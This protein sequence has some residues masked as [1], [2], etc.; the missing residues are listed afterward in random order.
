MSEPN[1]ENPLASSSA[2]APLRLRHRLPK[3]LPNIANLNAASRVQHRTEP[4][5]PVAEKAAPP[6]S[7]A[8]ATAPAATAENV[9]TQETVQKPVDAA[10][11]AKQR[12]P[13][14]S[15]T[16]SG[17]LGGVANPTATPTPPLALFQSSNPSSPAAFSLSSSHHQHHASPSAVLRNHSIDSVHHLSAGS[18][19]PGHGLITSS[20]TVVPGGGG[21]LSYKQ[22]ANIHGFNSMVPMS[23]ATPNFGGPCTPGPIMPASVY[24]AKF[25]NEHIMNIIKHKT[26]QKLKKIESDGLKERRKRYQRE[27]ALFQAA[28]KSSQQA[29]LQLINT[30][31]NI[32]MSSGGGEGACSSSDVAS[33]LIDR[34]KLRMRDLLY[35]SPKSKRN[36][37][38]NSNE[39]ILETVEPM[40]L[41]VA[42]AAIS[43]SS[44]SSSLS[45]AQPVAKA[46]TYSAPQL[47]LAEDGSLIL[48]EES[49]IIHRTEVVPVFDSTVV[50]NDQNDNLSYN[51]YRKFHHTK[52]W[53]ERETAKFYKALSMIGTDFTMIQRLF[54]N[55]S[56]DEI[57]RK[58]KREEKLNQA[59][60]DKILSKTSQIDLSVFVTSSE[61]E[62]PTKS[63]KGKG[64]EAS[65]E[66]ADGDG[67]EKAAPAKKK[68]DRYNLK[69][70]KKRA[71]VE[72]ESED[73][74]EKKK[75][76]RKDF[77]SG[78]FDPS[79]VVSEEQA[80]LGDNKPKTS[81]KKPQ[82]AP[83]GV[84]KVVSFA[85]ATS[86]GSPPTPE[87]TAGAVENAVDAVDGDIF[88]TINGVIQSFCHSENGT[89]D[90]LTTT[91][92]SVPSPFI[93]AVA[94]E[95]VVAIPEPVVVAVP[96]V[97]PPAQNLQKEEEATEANEQTSLETR[98]SPEVAKDESAIDHQH[99][100][101][102][103]EPVEHEQEDEEVIDLIFDVDNDLVQEVNDNPHPSTSSGGPQGGGKED[104]NVILLD[105]DN[106]TFVV[107]D[108]VTVIDLEK[109]AEDMRQLELQE[110]QLLST[111]T[112]ITSTTSNSRSAPARSSIIIT[113][114]NQSS[115]PSNSNKK[116]N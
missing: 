79:A 67:Q 107:N 104:E 6:P 16:N 89:L 54:A 76:N 23:P 47:K 26:L 100:S 9:S 108:T 28:D 41:T 21:G 55:R 40:P 10:A 46:P 35:Y 91:T 86:A 74:A 13:L 98:M 77:E 101:K 105:L 90:S 56:R 45:E 78:E 14:I 66:T 88:E 62:E 97:D 59:L 7:V 85:A 2:A 87:E 18:H 8:T 99:Q 81:L 65:A 5:P 19:S 116:H 96:P 31:S 115:T 60:I 24:N 69:R 49:L 80:V 39:I 30:N 51:S 93:N 83:K 1:S 112:P 113:K 73:E 52:K 11:A 109:E 27:S 25:S 36:E 92:T 33:P 61:D 20:S 102:E 114:R 95:T 58:F 12:K 75:S 48:N 64:K 37:R 4:A 3:A 42:T 82:R 103:P 34:S 84:K 32:S 17:E 71:F 57:K 43:Q 15:T 29:R 106:N 68:H 110:I 53:S 63:R 111:S 38:R 72:S 22:Y 50:E 94:I 44:S 70:V